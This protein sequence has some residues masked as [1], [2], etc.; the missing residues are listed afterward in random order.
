MW[1]I[2]GPDPQIAHTPCSPANPTNHSPPLVNATVSCQLN[3]VSHIKQPTSVST[4]RYS[5]PARSSQSE[6]LRTQILPPPP[7]NRSAVCLIY[8][9]RPCNCQYA[10]KLRVA[11]YIK[12]IECRGGAPTW[13]CKNCRG[14]NGR[15]GKVIV[16]FSL[17]KAEKSIGKE[18]AV[19]GCEI[20]NKSGFKQDALQRYEHMTGPTTSH[21]KLLVLIHLNFPTDND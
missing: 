19:Q 13:S 4:P 11:I 3:L 9:Y 16:C 14:I 17:L 10:N 18:S 2:A 8:M 1:Q 20:L 12:I 6:N 21:R 5:L 7:F 15:G